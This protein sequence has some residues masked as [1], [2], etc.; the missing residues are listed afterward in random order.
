MS[1]KLI[2]FKFPEEL[3]K[4]HVNPVILKRTVRQNIRERSPLR[5]R[6]Y[7]SRRSRSPLPHY[8]TRVRAE[9]KTEI[10]QLFLIN[11]NFRNAQGHPLDRS[12]TIADHPTGSRYIAVTMTLGRSIG[13]RRFSDESFANSRKTFAEAIYH[14]LWR[15]PRCIP[16]LC[17]DSK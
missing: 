6:D 5:S 4:T 13:R 1:C 2:R 8:R 17:K 11:S 10:R 12:T 9:Y 3:M 14:Q 15:R 7:E 16:A